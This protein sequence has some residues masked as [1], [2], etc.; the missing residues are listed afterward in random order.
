[1]EA[2]EDELAVFEASGGDEPAVDD[3]CDEVVEALGDEGE[4]EEG[5]QG[6]W[7][8]DVDE[9]LSRSVYSHEMQW[10]G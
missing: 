2:L 4:G 1:V 7:G 3:A 8:Q 5:A 9:D 10:P 6:D